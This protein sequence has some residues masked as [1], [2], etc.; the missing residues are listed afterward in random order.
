MRR[1]WYVLA[2]GILA[3]GLITVPL[4]AKSHNGNDGA[5]LGIYPQTV[6]KELAEVFDLPVDYGVVINEVIEDSPAEKA[7]L[8]EDDVIIS[9]NGKRIANADRLISLIGRSEPGD[10]VTL[11]VMRG[12]DKKEITVTLGEKPEEDWS[13][14]TGRNPANVRKYFFSY[15][16]DNERGGY[17]GVG[18]TNLTPQLGDYFGV[19]KGNGAL[20]TEVMKDS[21]AKEAG[22]RAGDVIVSIDGEQVEDI[23]DVQDIIGEKEPGDK[24]TITVVR[25]KKEKEFTVEVGEGDEDE[26]VY[27]FH[28]MF[29]PDVYFNFPKMKGRF[30]P[31][32]PFPT[33]NMDE[34]F[35][36][37]ELEEQMEKLRDELRSLQKE[38]KEIQKKLD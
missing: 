16:S 4:M 26:D 19:E 30:F 25:Q 9:I 35:D 13:F 23:E 1:A 33:L 17:I 11:T 27:S 21:P 12:D 20:I 34:D 8:K 14:S 36:Q 37:G 6:D 2:A 7:G 38:M 15:E 3:I 18:L 24:V 5:W 31:F 29:D 32:P 28:Q 22:L 10:E